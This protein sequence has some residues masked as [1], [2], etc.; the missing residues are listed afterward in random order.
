MV[1]SYQRSLKILQPFTSNPEDI[2]D[3]LRTMRM[4]T[5]GRTAVNSE[6]KDFEDSIN[7]ASDQSGSQGSGQGSVDRALGQARAFARE[8]HNDLMFTIRSLQD[9]V[10]MMSGLPGKKSVIYLSDGLPMTPG[11]D[12]FYEIEEKFQD[13]SAISQSTEFDST[14]LYRGLVT[15]AAAAGVTF[16]TIDAKG[17]QSELG[18]DAENQQ[19]RS[20]LAASVAQSNDQ[21]SLRYI[22]EQ[23]GGLAVVNTNDVTP[24]LERIAADMETYYSLGYRLVPTGEDR[25]HRVEVKVKGHP[26]YHLNYRKT[27]IEKSLPTRIGDRVMSGLTFDLEDNPMNISLSAGAPAPA[28]SGRWT[29]PVEIKLP[30]DKIA[31]VPQGDDLVGYLMAYYAARDNE[32][33]QS[34]LQRVEHA[35]KIPKQDYEKARHEQYTF[36]ASLLLEPGVY[37]ISV[38]IRDELTNQAGYAGLRQ[39]VHPESK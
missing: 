18:I 21:D 9:L 35:V 2:A 13:P 39:A 15:S 11:L 8:Q 3:A 24:G 38:G 5:G 31:L 32:G 17:L 30:I 7:Q 23:T 14:S 12:L 36:S 22:A 27:F 25:V 26:E 29:L 33:K 19:P 4:Y 10:S 28:S 37:R 1:V 16:Y 6:R 34:D 20:T